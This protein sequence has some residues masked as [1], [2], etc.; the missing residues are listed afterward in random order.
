MEL[1]S[2]DALL[3]SSNTYDSDVD[4]FHFQLGGNLVIKKIDGT[5]A[6]ESKAVYD[7]TSFDRALD[8]LIV[9]DDGDV[10]LYASI[11]AKWRTSTYGK[12]LTGSILRQSTLINF[13]IRKLGNIL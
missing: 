11:Q 6:W 8:H 5:N 3:W 13:P 12:C 2:K 7:K 9:Q 10:V 4:V 1:F